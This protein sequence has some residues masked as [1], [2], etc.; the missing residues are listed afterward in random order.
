ML[1]KTILLQDSPLPSPKK[2][3]IIQERERGGSLSERKHIY[4]NSGWK[5]S[6]QTAKI[7]FFTS[8]FAIKTIPPDQWQKNWLEEK[9]KE[10]LGMG[11]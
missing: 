6:G 4:E 10:H 11:L 1:R 9:R 2:L 5:I 8:S 7:F 3:F